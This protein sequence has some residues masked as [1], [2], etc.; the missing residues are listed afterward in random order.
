MKTAQQKIGR[1]HFMAKTISQTAAK[2]K[3]S[4]TP[5][6]GRVA[7]FWV[8]LSIIILQSVAR[9]PRNGVMDGRGAEIVKKN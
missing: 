7:R 3:A 2:V 6:K 5:G 9:S 1:K 8:P 4:L